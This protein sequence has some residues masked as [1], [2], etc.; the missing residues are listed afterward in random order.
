MVQD[1]PRPSSEAD[2]LRLLADEL[3]T[4][5]PETWRSEVTLEPA[6]GRRRPDAT[7][8]LTAPDGTSALLLVEAKSTLNA[9]DVPAVLEQLTALQQEAGSANAD[10]L[11]PPLVVARYIGPRTREVL[12]DAGASYADATGNLHLQVERPAVYMEAIG[13]ASD[14]WRGPERKTSTLRGRPAA[15]VVRALVDF[16]PPVGIRALSHRSG[17]SLGSTYR[18]VDFLD[19]EALVQRDPSGAVIDVAWP[20][21]L[22]RWSEDYSFQGS[23]SVRPA[24]EPRGSGRLLQNLRTRDITARYAVT[25]SLSAA[26]VAQVA[27][28]R[29]ALVFTDDPVRFAEQADV[30][31]SGPSTN[32]LLA[33]PFDAVALDRTIEADGV[34][35]A[36]LSQTAVDLLTS[37]GRGPVEA[38]ALIEWMKANED[39]WR[40]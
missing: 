33:T 34:T 6:F 40:R 1:I 8:R 13:A 30:R 2:L 37:P 26:R 27:E 22:L 23:N 17:A 36:A 19:R 38:A 20:D 12:A 15:K 11:G 32:V 25:G 28:T 24:F 10:E 4:R 21:L 14:P 31:L 16:K 35:Y 29:L 39:A 9:R 5:L 18:A 3:A 7:V